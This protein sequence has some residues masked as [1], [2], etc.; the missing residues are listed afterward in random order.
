MLMQT[1]S[2]VVK[3]VWTA[4]D[5]LIFAMPDIFVSAEFSEEDNCSNSAAIGLRSGRPVLNVLMVFW[6]GAQDCQ[7]SP[8]C[9]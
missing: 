8:G 4:G 2:S 5:W 1:V 3:V 7:A 9:R 6:C